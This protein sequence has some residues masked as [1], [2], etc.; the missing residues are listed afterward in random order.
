MLGRAAGSRLE[1]RLREPQRERERDE[2]LLRAVVEVALEP[3]ARL[4][5][6]GDD[7]AARGPELLLLAAGAR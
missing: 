4:V 6:R 7:A 1:L 2:A 3:A 5:A